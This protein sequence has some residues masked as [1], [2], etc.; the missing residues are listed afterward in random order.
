MNRLVHDLLDYS[1]LTRLELN[2]TDVEIARVAEDALQQ[3]EQKLRGCVHLNVAKGL[4]AYV[5]PAT[6]TQV[7]YNLISNGL[8]FGKPGVEP[9]VELT[10]AVEGERIRIEVRDEGIGIPSQ[11]H[12]RVFQVFEKLHAPSKYPGT[13]IGLA[14]VKRGITRMGG[15]VRLSS[16]P[17]KGSTFTIEVPAA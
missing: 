2:P 4:R 14:I 3:V 11:H 10:A 7:L 17:G 1:R 12:E 5:H 16:E 9:W 13:G 15:T 8:K 6:L